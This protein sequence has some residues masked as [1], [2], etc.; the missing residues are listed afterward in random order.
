MAKPKPYT[1]I[2]AKFLHRLGY[3]DLSKHDVAVTK[4]LLLDY[5]GYAVCSVEEKPAR[6]LQGLAA[7][8]GGPPEATI[9]GTAQR[10][11]AV[12]ASL[13]NG[14]MGHITELD[15]THRGT[16]SHMG[17][18]V[19]P[20]ALAVGEKTGANGKDVLAAIVAGYDCG[21]RAGYSVMPGH[22]FKGWHPSGTINAFGAAMAAGKILGLDEDQLLHCIGLA[23]TQTAGN[24]AHIPV[25]GMSKD[26]NPGKGAFNG[27]FS[28]FLARDGFTG[29]FD[30]FE[31]EKGF[32]ALYADRSRPEKLIGNLGKPFLVGEVAHKKYPGCYHLHSSRVAAMD[33]AR[34]HG[35]RAADIKRV[36]ARFQAIGAFYIDDPVPWIGIKGLYGPRF[37]MQFQIALAL[38]EGEDGMWASYDDE[39]VLKKMK[40]RRVRQ[41]M[42]RIKLVPD[43]GFDKI[44]PDKQP[45]VVTI[46][47]MN[48]KSYTKRVDVPVGE[49]ENP[50][51]E[52]EIE[53][54]FDILAGSRFSPRRVARIKSAVDDLEKLKD[55]SKLTR[56]LRR[57]RAFA[58]A[59]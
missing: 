42:K 39:Y 16:Q 17:D 59:A 47:A 57:E 5:I 19:L 9:I 22:Y 28:A 10:T 4:S 36:V 18:S 25:R 27:V 20:A 13:V 12:W 35:L 6:I 53:R 41:V 43:K 38:C 24:V 11:G 32:M 1:R 33:I 46:T 51:S 55:I 58:R 26:L 3:R 30:I 7:E 56:L 23:G 52:A 8:M 37:S 21:L 29:C 34:E 31:S 2:L 45:A 40:D 15:D 14:S 49:P 50:M 54:K 44:W 48:G